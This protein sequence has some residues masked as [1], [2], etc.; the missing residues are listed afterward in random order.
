[1]RLLLYHELKGIFKADQNSQRERGMR[2]YLRAV[3]VGVGKQAVNLPRRI[4]SLVGLEDEGAVHAGL[5]VSG[6][7]HQCHRSRVQY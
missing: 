3:L 2:H 1:M 7:S 4:A 5:W 6:L